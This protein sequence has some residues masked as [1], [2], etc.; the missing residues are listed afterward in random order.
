MNPIQQMTPMPTLY[1]TTCIPQCNMGLLSIPQAG[2]F[3]VK[4]RVGGHDERPKTNDSGGRHQLVLVQAQQVFGIAEQNL[5]VPAGCDVIQ[6]GC[7]ILFQS[8]DAQY[9]TAW[10]GQS[11]A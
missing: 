4:E 1:L 10:S 2:T 11:S 8:L 9:R 3:L 5:N 7:R 6:Q